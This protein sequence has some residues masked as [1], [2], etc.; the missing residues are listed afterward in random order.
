MKKLYILAT[1]AIL[2]NGM[3][4]AQQQF[5]PA[6]GSE[7]APN[8]NVGN[9]NPTPQTPWQLLYSIDITGAGAGVGNAGVVVLGNEV[10]VSKWGSDTISSFTLTGTLNSQFTVPGVTG[11]RSLTTDGTSIYAGANTSSI[12]KIDPLTRTLTSTISTGIT[13]IRYCTYDPTLPGFWV[14]TWATDFSLVDMTGTP[15]TDV[16]ATNHLLTATYG[17]AYDGASPGGPYLWAFH[18]T[19][20]TNAADLIQVNIATGLQTSVIHDVT[21]DIGTAGDLAG[22]ICI[23]PAP[24][25]SIVGV[26]QGAANLVFAYDI[27][28][29]NG[30]NEP[31]ADAPFVSAFP[32]PANDMVNIQ[33]DRKN[34]E[35]MTM[36]MFDVTGR[37]VFESNNVGVNNYINMAGFDAGIYTVKVISND[38]VSTTQVV[39][40]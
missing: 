10:W 9:E 12:Y 23:V 20:A 18:Q 22:G 15:N 6:N 19:G 29:V 14:G 26:L 13:N 40:N 38:Q 2:S 39:K 24:V 3:L 35:E 32:N 7:V 1:A 30:M 27:V 25:L 21:G 16:L 31:A 34:N 17:L 11:V 36:Q 8:I 28:G 37:V 5:T 33:V 4:S